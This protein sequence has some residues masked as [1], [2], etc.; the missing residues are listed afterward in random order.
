MLT[1]FMRQWSR[2]VVVPITRLVGWSGVS[3]NLVT[4]AGFV[5][6]AADA[7]V[8]S[9]GYVQAAGALLILA[10]VLDAIDGSL[11]RMLGQV[12]RFGAFLDSTLDRY[13]EAVIFLGALIYTTNYGGTR[14]EILL[15]VVALVGSLMVS[16]TKAR[17]EAIGIAIRGGLLTRFERIVI[18][19]IA[20]LLNELTVA[21]W[22]L[23][24]LTNVTALQRIWLVWKA[25]RN[26]GGKQ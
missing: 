11:A 5:L 20:M 22:I 8:L 13:S 15:I 6:T 18:L 23:A 2:G 14:N 21:F 3:P 19:I 12:T 9:L 1:D 4:V 24:I 7:V 17:G 16:Y 26:D 10:G 25:T